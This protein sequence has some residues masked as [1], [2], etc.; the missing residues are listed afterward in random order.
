MPWPGSVLY[1][2]C[3]RRLRRSQVLVRSILLGPDEGP[4]K[5]LHMAQLHEGRE[6]LEYFEKG[7]ELL[8]KQL[9]DGHARAKE[10]KAGLKQ[11][12]C[13]AYCSVGELYMTDLCFEEDAE[14]RCQVRCALHVLVC[15]KV[16]STNFAHPWLDSI[17]ARFFVSDV[18]TLWSLV[19]ETGLCF[20]GRSFSPKYRTPDPKFY[21]QP[22]SSPSHHSPW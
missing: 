22:K 9:G 13:M 17:P 18:I 15:I 16:R 21:Q 20:R 3:N 1:Q 12:L 6:A 2:E 19:P 7:L 8:Q 14:K 5:Y 4:D 11:R 10:E